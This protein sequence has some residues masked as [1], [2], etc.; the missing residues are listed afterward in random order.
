MAFYARRFLRIFPLYA[1][2][3]IA[4]VVL[5]PIPQA[6]GTPSSRLWEWLF[7]TNVVMTQRTPD[8]IGFLFGHL[9]SLAIEEQFYIVWPLVIL[10]APLRRLPL[11]CC[12]LL[13][14]SFTGRALFLAAGIPHY[15]WL[16]MPTR[17]DGLVVGALVAI[18]QRH[19]PTLLAKAATKLWIPSVVMAGA[20]FVGLC[21]SFIDAA[22]PRLN[23]FGNEFAGRRLE[24]LFSPFAGAVL[25]GCIVAKVSGDVVPRRARWLEGKQLGLV[26]KSSYGM[27]L[28]HT[29]ILAIPY[30]L[31]LPRHA[32]SGLA[33]LIYQAGY[34]AVVIALSHAFG[35]I[36]WHALEKQFLRLSPVYRFRDRIAAPPD[37]SN[38][39]DPV[40]VMPA[41]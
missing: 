39:R 37:V 15:G 11:I 40:P 14:A 32:P 27:Y 26:G 22:P 20:V 34:S 13:A 33:G 3:L 41:P 18:L 5:V 9:W 1:A 8:E 6:S 25:F 28:F 19:N 16:L 30:L 23:T 31:G 7:L 36:T 17:L 29:L 38:S 24:I 12:A 21:A 4:A 10:L 2:Y 35:L